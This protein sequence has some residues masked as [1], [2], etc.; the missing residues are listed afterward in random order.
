M[1]EAEDK[2]VDKYDFHIYEVLP[3]AEVI[4]RTIKQINGCLRPRSE[5]RIK[6]L[7][8]KYLGVIKI[9]YT[10]IVVIV[11]DSKELIS[12]SYNMNDNCTKNANKNFLFA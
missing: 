10:L 4:Y 7:Y 2:I 11:E 8:K 6:K 9:L 5:K 3:Q 1:K 12:T